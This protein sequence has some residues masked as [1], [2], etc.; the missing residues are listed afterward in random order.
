[1]KCDACG[2]SVTMMGLELIAPDFHVETERTL[3]KYYKK[4]ENVNGVIIWHFCYE[5]VIDKL[6]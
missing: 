3:G 1:M 2:K 6:L 5:C 4:K